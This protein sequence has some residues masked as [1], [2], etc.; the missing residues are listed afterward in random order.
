MAMAEM[1]AERDER[2]RDNGGFIVLPLRLVLFGVAQLGIGALLGGDWR[3]AAAW[4]PLSALA[5]NLVTIGLLALLLRA[6]R[7]SYWS[8]FRF[9]KGS[10]GKD[11]P[12]VLASVAALVP[13]ALL[14]N[15][16]LAG[17]LFGDAAIAQHMLLQP[18]PTWAIWVSVLF[19]LTIPFAELPLYFGYAMPRIEAKTGS[20]ILA[21]G[22]AALFLAAQHVTLPLIWDGR[23]MV[24]RFLMFL[25]LAMFLAVVVRIRPSLLP[26]LVVIHGLLDL[27]V[28]AVLAAGPA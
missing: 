7:R 16:V 27:S 3:V 8:L 23:F 2:Q 10:V 5:A 6:E 14:P 11:W 15:V 18:L 17:W 12:W 24:W 21:A 20:A 9:R 28:V 26:Y 13:L 4:W 22:L 1:A 25:P 19:P